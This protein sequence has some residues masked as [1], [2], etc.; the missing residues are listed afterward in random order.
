VKLFVG[1]KNGRRCLMWKNNVSYTKIV[2][3]ILN[4]ITEKTQ[5]TNKLLIRN[6][7]EV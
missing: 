7:K 4:S 5:L 2:N 1:K 6:K 3:T